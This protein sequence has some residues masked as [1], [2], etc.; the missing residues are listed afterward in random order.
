MKTVI[1]DE[2]SELRRV[3]SGVP[4]G[5]VLAAVMFLRSINDMVDEVD[6]YANL[7]SYDAKLMMRVK[8]VG[9]CRQLQED[10]DKIYEWS[11]V[12]KWNL[13]SRSIK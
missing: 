10:L 8:N 4:Q 11:R 9:G 13:M 6:N 3:T 12:W 5:S 1:R 7:F 2:A